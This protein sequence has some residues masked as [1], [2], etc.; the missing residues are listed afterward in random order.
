[1]I[2]III[3]KLSN[4]MTEELHAPK[5]LILYVKRLSSYLYNFDT[6]LSFM[7]T[8]KLIYRILYLQANRLLYLAL[9]KSF[10]AT[11]K[12]PFTTKPSV[13]LYPLSGPKELICNRRCLNP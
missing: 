3:N 6:Y 5:A 13:L 11:D 2:N 12:T 9:S 10:P 4:T 1:M 8:T 7:N